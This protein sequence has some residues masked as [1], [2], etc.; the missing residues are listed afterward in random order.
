MTSSNSTTFVLKK[1]NVSKLDKTHI[2]P[3]MAET[4]FKTSPRNKKTKI[5]DILDDVKKTNTLDD[6]NCEKIVITHGIN[7]ILFYTTV[8]NEKIEQFQSSERPLRCYHCH[9]NIIK[10]EF[11][12]GIPLRLVNDCFECIGITCGFE[13]TATHIKLRRLTGDS[14][15][16]NSDVLLSQL[17]YRLHGKLIPKDIAN[18]PLFAYEILNSYGG[19]L[20]EYGKKHM[21]ATHINKKIQKGSEEHRSITISILPSFYEELK[22]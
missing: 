17:Y 11:F 19:P 13:C 2:I 4:S 6:D 14:R 3:D 22:K 10:G 5:K 16:N 1:I 8:G 9:S 15:F 21:Y 18:R 20:K 12:L 7:K